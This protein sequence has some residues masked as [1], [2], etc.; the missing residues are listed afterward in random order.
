[1][2]GRGILEIETKLMGTSSIW[3]LREERGEVE[4]GRESGGEVGTDGR[5][6][7]SPDATGGSTRSGKE[8]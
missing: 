5:H 7:V 4:S 1:M 6:A 2:A 3:R 8:C